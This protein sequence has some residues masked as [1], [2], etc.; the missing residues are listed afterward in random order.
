MTSAL[1]HGSSGTIWI[2][3]EYS[4]RLLPLERMREM[5]DQLPEPT[6][7]RMPHGH[8]QNFIRACKGLEPAGA[9][10]DYAAPLT[11]IVLAGAVA[12]RLP[13]RRLV[14]NPAALKF[15]GDPEATALIHRALV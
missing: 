5:K 13:G 3:N 1:L 7:P 15:E 11:E 14:Y 10:F 6:I 12:Q 4:P 9:S 8:Y 2:N